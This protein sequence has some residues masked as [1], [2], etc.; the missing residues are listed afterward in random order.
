[1]GW[2]LHLSPRGSFDSLGCYVAM[3]LR[4]RRGLFLSPLQE[5]PEP[6]DMQSQDLGK[7]CPHIYDPWEVPGFS[8]ENLRV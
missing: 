6:R 5:G 2:G 4:F 3:A 7:G 8:G 1:M